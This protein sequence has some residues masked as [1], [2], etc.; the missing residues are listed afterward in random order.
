MNPNPPPPPGPAGIPQQPSRQAPAGARE[1][2]KHGASA[3]PH[4]SLRGLPRRLPVFLRH[5]F[6]RLSSTFFAFCS[7]IRHEHPDP[8]TNLLRLF[9]RFFSSPR[10]RRHPFEKCPHRGRLSLVKRTVRGRRAE[11]DSPY[12]R[13]KAKGE[14]PWRSGIISMRLMLTC[15]PSPTVQKWTISA[16]SSPVMATGALS[17][18]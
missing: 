12:E 8:I 18:A 11:I 14:K 6:L 16:M 5:M 9:K 15:W 13:S 3:L 10:A 2:R 17:P 1:S 7:Y 4:R